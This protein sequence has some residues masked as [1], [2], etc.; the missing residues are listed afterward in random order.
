MNREESR[1]M[2]DA[3][4]EHPQSKLRRYLIMVVVAL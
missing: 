1:G 4:E 3:A 2:L